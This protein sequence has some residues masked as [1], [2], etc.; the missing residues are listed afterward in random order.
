MHG[1]ARVAVDCGCGRPPALV[2]PEVV[3]VRRRAL[4]VVAGGA[5]LCVVRY[6]ILVD[7]CFFML[8]NCFNGKEDN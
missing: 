4:P 6:F 7:F 8:A 1:H 5:R 2:V 3:G